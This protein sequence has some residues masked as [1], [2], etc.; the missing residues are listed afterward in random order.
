METVN[1]IARMKELI[2]IIADADTAYY[3]DDAPVL[4]DREYD[5]LT[6]ELKSLEAA[7][8]IVFANSPTK[9]VGGSN[10]AELKQVKHSKPMLHWQKWTSQNNEK[11]DCFGYKPTLPRFFK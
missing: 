1:S 3:R 4:S 11:E 6:E 5:A 7:T 8:G 10:N 9:K 2:G